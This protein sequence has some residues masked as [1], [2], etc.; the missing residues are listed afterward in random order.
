MKKK[1]GGFCLELVSPE[2]R[3]AS[4]QIQQKVGCLPSPVRPGFTGDA[5]YSIPTVATLYM[6][7]DQHEICNDGGDGE[8]GTYSS[9]GKTL[10]QN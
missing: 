6:I 8:V 5:S 1:E 10:N 4:R 9:D 2:V 7:A 3:T